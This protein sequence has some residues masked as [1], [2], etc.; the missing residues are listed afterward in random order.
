MFKHNNEPRTEHLDCSY[1]VQPIVIKGARRTVEGTQRRIVCSGLKHEAAKR[2]IIK[3][4]VIFLKIIHVI[5]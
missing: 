3:N 4:Y 1:F 5:E 2:T